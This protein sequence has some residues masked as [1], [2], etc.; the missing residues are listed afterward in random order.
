ML[1]DA[2][3]GGEIPIVDSASE[4]TVSV[5]FIGQYIIRRCLH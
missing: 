2:P 4:V 3:V 5:S 1:T